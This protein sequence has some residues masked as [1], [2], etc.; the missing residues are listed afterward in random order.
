MHNFSLLKSSLIIVFIVIVVIVTSCKSKKVIMKPESETANNVS[1]EGQ[2]VDYEEAVKK[3]FEMQ[4]DNTKRM[5]LRADKNRVR[6]NSGISRNWYDKLFNNSCFRNSCMVK[7]GHDFVSITKS[8]S[9][10]VKE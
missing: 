3:H 6:Y 9:C 2:A 5:M 10:F 1:E 4:S 8:R 7:T